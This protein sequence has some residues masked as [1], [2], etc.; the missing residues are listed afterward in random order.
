[1][2]KLLRQ[3]SYYLNVTDPLVIPIIFIF[4]SFF[5]KAH[6]NKEFS[7]E[8]SKPC[9]ESQITI[10]EVE[11]CTNTYIMSIFLRLHAAKQLN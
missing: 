11:A 9:C 7:R 6:D 10:H 3:L 5:E 4:I 8:V 1:M 2:F